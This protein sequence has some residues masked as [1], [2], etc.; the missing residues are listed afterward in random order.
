MPMAWRQASTVSRAL[1]DNAFGVFNEGRLGRDHMYV[2]AG[3]RQE[4]ALAN[5]AFG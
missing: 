2:Y 4:V 1:E 5:L 3:R